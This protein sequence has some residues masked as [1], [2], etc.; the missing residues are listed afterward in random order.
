V[1]IGLLEMSESSCASAARPQQRGQAPTRSP[2]ACVVLRLEQ[3]ESHLIGSQPG[4]D[5][6]TNTYLITFTVNGVLRVFQETVQAT[7]TKTAAIAV[8]A[9]VEHAGLRLK[10]ITSIIQK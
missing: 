8:N 9:M 7:D 3:R 6:L 10:H 4:E 5:G 2:S 1:V